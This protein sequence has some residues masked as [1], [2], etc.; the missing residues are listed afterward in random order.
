[1]LGGIEGWM[2]GEKVRGGTSYDASS[3]N[4]YVL[5]LV[6]RRHDDV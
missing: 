4:D 2:T 3:D 5:S 6:F 1:M